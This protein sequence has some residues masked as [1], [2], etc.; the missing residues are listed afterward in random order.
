MRLSA[1]MF[2]VFLEFSLLGAPGIPL[3]DDLPIMKNPSIPDFQNRQQD[4]KPYD[5]DAPPEGMFRFITTAEGFEEELSYRRT[6]EIVPV[7]VTDRFRSDTAGIFIVFQLHQH[8]QAFQVF[9]LCFPESVTGLNPQAV[10]S[11]DAMYIALEDE[12][13]YLKLSPPPDGWGPGN[14]R[15]EIHAGE[16]VNE[17]SLMGTMRFTV[18]PA[19]PSS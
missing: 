8:Y 18:L 11:Q 1:Y 2:G 14:Y 13:G 16:Q 4:L 3:A 12:S 9:G 10:I 6:H 5:F 19:A 7:N 17:M 15:V